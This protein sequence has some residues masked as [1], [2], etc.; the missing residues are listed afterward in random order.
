MFFFLW[1]FFCMV[2]N[3][4]KAK[5]VLLLLLMMFFFDLK[6]KE[7]DWGVEGMFFY[8]FFL[9]LYKFKKRI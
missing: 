9:L 8:L 2:S 1:Y 7:A 4:R 3:L 5:K 6:F